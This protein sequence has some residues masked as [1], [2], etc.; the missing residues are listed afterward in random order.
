MA[1]D[2]DDFDNKN[3]VDKKP[4][5]KL[6]TEYSGDGGDDSGK[7]K[8]TKI[9]YPGD[10]SDD[11][12]NSDDLDENEESADVLKFI[13]QKGDS[14]SPSST[15]HDLLQKD[16]QDVMA[17]LNPR[18]RSILELRF[19][20][21]DGKTRTLAEV[22]E[23]FGLP[24]ER[25]RQIEAKALRKLR[26]PN[27]NRKGY[28]SQPSPPLNSPTNLSWNEIQSKLS[29]FKSLDRRILK[30]LWGFIDGERRTKSEVAQKFEVSEEY[31]SELDKQ[32]K[33]L[34]ESN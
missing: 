19:G 12:D 11:S 4:K 31:V 16:I 6:V 2:D 14:V 20:L 32:A 9:G 27:R 25:V 33:K 7:N 18:E 3:E 21:K 30:M 26:H 17:D 15:V 28:Y 8:I 22:A 1:D 13:A 5:L 29:Q 10:E 23:L 34:F 24:R